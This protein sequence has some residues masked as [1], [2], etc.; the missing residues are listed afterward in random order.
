MQTNE[1][2]GRAVAFYVIP[3]NT[4]PHLDNRVSLDDPRMRTLLREM[5]A[6]GHAV[7]IHP[8]TTPI[9]TRRP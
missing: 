2:V 8:A 9:A 1:R 7:G 4:D 6:R 5:H 3:E